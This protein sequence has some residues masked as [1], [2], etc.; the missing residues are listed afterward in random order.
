MGLFTFLLMLFL[1][2]FKLIW[3]V[4]CKTGLIVMITV[5]PVLSYAFLYLG[6]LIA[7][8]TGNWPDTFSPLGIIPLTRPSSVYQDLDYLGDWAFFWAFVAS[9]PLVLGV[10]ARTVIRLVRRDPRWTYR[11]A[12]R[13]RRAAKTREKQLEGVRAGRQD[14]TNGKVKGKS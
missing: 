14:A 3:K 6:A 13:R 11:A 7:V 2:I 4:L 1:L 10:L 9:V 5:F 8:K 12:L